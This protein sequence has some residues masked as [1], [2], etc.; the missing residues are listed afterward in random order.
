MPVWTP[1]EVWKDQ[2]VFI[3]GGGPSL[4]DFDWTLLHQEYTIGC[5]TAFTLGEKVCKI[6]VFGDKSWFHVFEEKLSQFKGA[7][8]TNIEAYHH[9]NHL[10]WLWTLRRHM[11]GLHKDGLGWNGNTGSIAI[12]LALLLGAKKVYLMGYDMQRINDRPNWHDQ[13]IR[14]NA[15]RPQI[16][17]RFVRDF[18]FV[19]RD[20]HLKFSDREII[21]LTD[22][23]GLPPA[24]FPWVSPGSF[25]EQ[26][27]G[28]RLTGEKA[29]PVL[30]QQR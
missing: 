28:V 12:N 17:E 23:S 13:V 2:E 27:R 16:Y 4:K 20:W 15:C 26:R 10:P 19:A 22:N 30:I 29:C 18:S 14:P 11:T 21:N 24:L 7:V 8:F 6:C 25:W 3:I 9:R 5:N 1:E